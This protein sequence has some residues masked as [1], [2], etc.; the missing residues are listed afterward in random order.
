MKHILVVDYTPYKNVL[1]RIYS[2]CGYNVTVCE[3]AFEAISKLRAYD[4]DLIVSE[5]E[6]PGDNAFDLYNYLTANYPYIPT[7]MITSK[8]IDNF[9]ERIIE[10]GI[11]NVLTKPVRESEILNLSDKLISRD[12]IFDLKNYMPDLEELKKIRINNS[13][14]INKAV[15][16]IMEGIESWNFSLGNKGFFALILHEMIINALYHSHGYTEEKKARVPLAL[17]EGKHVDVFFGRGPEN[18][19]VSINDYQGNLTRTRILESI[20]CAIKQEKLLVQA[21]ETGE[22]I[23]DFISE[24]GRGID[25]LRKLAREYYFIIK[26]DFRTEIILIFNATGENGRQRASSLKIIEDITR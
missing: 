23:S 22:D 21:A 5:V 9:F 24:T 15:H 11:G 16:A 2:E 10:E 17:P 20:H 6:L 26:K 19:G 13:K 14:Q 1:A 8:T 25:L 7:I 12:N 3:S 18:Y 4:Y